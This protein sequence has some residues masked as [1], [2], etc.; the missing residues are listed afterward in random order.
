MLFDPDRAK[1]APQGPRRRKLVRSCCPYLPSISPNAM[2]TCYLRWILSTQSRSPL[3]MQGFEPSI[4]LD[5][6]NG[7][8]QKG[9]QLKN[10]FFGTF[11]PSSMRSRDTVKMQGFELAATW[12]PRSDFQNFF[13]GPRRAPRDSP[14]KG[15]LSVFAPSLCARL[16]EQYPCIFKRDYASPKPPTL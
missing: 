6:E 2:A 1:W 9:Y 8:F 7:F 3:K 16:A 11:L 13:W 15:K 5:F 12:V 10:Y 14:G 4:D